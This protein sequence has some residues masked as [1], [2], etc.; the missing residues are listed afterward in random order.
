ML[1]MTAEERLPRRVRM[2]P[3]CS[4][5]CRLCSRVALVRCHAAIVSTVSIL[6]KVCVKRI[7]QCTKGHTHETVR[8]YGK[9]TVLRWLALSVSTCVAKFQKTRKVIPYDMAPQRWG[10]FQCLSRI[11]INNGTNRYRCLIELHSPMVVA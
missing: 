11:N 1:N 3:P 4:R 6:K 2:N 7:G 5:P 8:A 9:L 10:K